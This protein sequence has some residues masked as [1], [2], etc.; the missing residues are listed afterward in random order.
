MPA[1]QFLF[2]SHDTFLN[3]YRRYD[4]KLI[5]S[6]LK[7]HDI[8]VE[9]IFY[10][11]SSLFVIRCIEKC[12]GGKEK[13]KNEGIGSWKYSKKNLLT[14]VIVSILNIDF[15]VA[16]FCQHIGVSLPGLSLCVVCRKKH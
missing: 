8:I 9:E 2:S 11:Y 6:I 5:L 13:K 10:F 15:I 7:K 1:Y 12:L 16:R 14:R 3:H 4:K